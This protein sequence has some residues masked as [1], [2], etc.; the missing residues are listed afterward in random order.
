[1]HTSSRVR[2]VLEFQKEFAWIWLNGAV[3]VRVRVRVRV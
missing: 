2:V 1:M 3:R